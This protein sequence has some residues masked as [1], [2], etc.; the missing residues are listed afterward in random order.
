VISPCINSNYIIKDRIDSVPTTATAAIGD[1]K[2][3]SPSIIV[4]FQPRQSYRK[5]LS[6]WS[7]HLITCSRGPRRELF[8]ACRGVVKSD[9]D[10]GLA[11]LPFLVD[12]ALR[13]G[14][15]D[16]LKQIKYV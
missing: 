15:D 3:S 7:R 14:T 1:S 5:W 12:N 9:V 8:R 11:L 13:Y 10:T 2:T 4:F 6:E 16:D